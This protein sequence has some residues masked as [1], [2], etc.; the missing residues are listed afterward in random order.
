MKLVRIIEP[1][2][3]IFLNQKKEISDNEIPLGNRGI[4]TYA[5]GLGNKLDSALF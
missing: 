5:D 3:K 4:Y 1:N 2:P